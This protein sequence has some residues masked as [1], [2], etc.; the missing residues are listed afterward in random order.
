VVESEREAQGWVVIGYPY[1]NW[2]SREMR[3]DQGRVKTEGHADYHIGKYSFRG[4]SLQA[5]NP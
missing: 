1:T 3:Q 2:L 4:C 5:M